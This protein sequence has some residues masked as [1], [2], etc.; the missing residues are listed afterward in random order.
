MMNFI[1][2][3]NP[4]LIFPQ[5]NPQ[6]KLRLFCFPYAGG[7]ASIFREWY[8]QLNREIEFVQCSY[9]EEKIG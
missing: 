7:G 9:Q 6:A 2:T 4:W 1:K 5:P 3:K 8:K